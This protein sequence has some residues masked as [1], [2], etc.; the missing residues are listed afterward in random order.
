MGSTGTTEGEEVSKATK[1]KKTA[2]RER[3]AAQIAAEQRREDA[4]KHGKTLVRHDRTSAAA[5]RRV[6]KRLEVSAPEALR[7]A[8]IELDAKGN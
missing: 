3:S 1:K 8:I 7:T 5:L 6:A 2:A 4:D